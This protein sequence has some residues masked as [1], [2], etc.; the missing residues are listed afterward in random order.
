MSGNDELSPVSLISS[1]DSVEDGRPDGRLGAVG[2]ALLM[3]VAV[4]ALVLV[5]TDRGSNQ[6]SPKTSDAS[7]ASPGGREIDPVRVG[8]GPVFGEPVG[9]VIAIGGS[10]QEIHLVDLDSGDVSS[11][12]HTGT[13]RLIHDGRLLIQ[14]GQAGWEVVDLADGG[15]DTIMP[16]QD[17][18]L[19][20]SVVAAEAG[21]VWFRHAEGGN[22]RAWSRIDPE[23]GQVLQ[24]V[25]LPVGAS[26]ATDVNG[27]PL[28]GPE[29]IGSETGE[30]Y[31]LGTTGEYQLM[32]D[33]HLIA[34]SE[35]LVLV[36]RCGLVACGNQW[37]DR[38]SNEVLD[39]PA[40]Q[41]QLAGA[42]IRDDS[43]LVA[44]TPGGSELIVKV[45][46]IPT[47]RAIATGSASGLSRS[48]VS[49]SGRFI[50]VPGFNALLII[51]V[52][53]GFTATIDRL[54]LEPDVQLAWGRT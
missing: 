18:A 54:S 15:A 7:S 23:S 27:L 6:L 10:R 35:H 48:W 11:L 21:G 19:Y 14:D 20:T 38:H 41:P 52:Q 42:F 49:P 43:M 40:P 25:T 22:G 32:L 8:E 3:V 2:A 1:R 26:V 37:I 17:T 36:S 33:A 31:T 34:F 24:E 29:V 5:S 30:V 13:P 51:D 12:G 16:E 28:A 45:F 50:A 9:L 39:I 4:V 46:D 44:E 47:G 53:D